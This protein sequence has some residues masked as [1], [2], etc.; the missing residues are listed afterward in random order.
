MA[1]SQEDIFKV[2]DS[3]YIKVLNGIGNVSPSIE[4]FAEDYLKKKKIKKMLLK[5]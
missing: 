4:E 2:L 5:I 3:I 1:M